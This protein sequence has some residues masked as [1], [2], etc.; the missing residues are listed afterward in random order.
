MFVGRASR[1]RDLSKAK[2]N[3]L[4]YFID[5]IDAVAYA[6]AACGSHDEREQTKPHPKRAF[7]GPASKPMLSIAATT[8]QT[9]P[10]LPSCARAVCQTSYSGS[11]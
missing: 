9:F 2:R 1:V 8:V 7:D 6:E 4:Y 5:E 10:I 11:T 3:A